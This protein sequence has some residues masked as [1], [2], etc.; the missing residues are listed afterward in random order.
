VEGLLT[1]VTCVLDMPSVFGIPGREF[2][3][4]QAACRAYKDVGIRAYVCPLI[5]DQPIDSTVAL[6]CGLRGNRPPADPQKTDQLI[7]FMERAIEELHRPE[8]GIE[9]G[10]GPSGMQ[11][12]SDELFVRCRELSEKHGLVQHT[13]LL[14]T[15]N[16]KKLAYEKYGCSAVEHLK[17]LGFFNEKTTCAHSVWLDAKDIELLKDTGATPVHNPLSNLRLGSGIAPVLKYL[18]ANINVCFGCDGAASNDSQDML[19]AIK[20]GSILHNITDFDYLRWITP[21]QAFRMAALGGA[22]AVG[23][24]GK[25]GLVEAGRSADLVLYDLSRSLSILPRTDILGLLLLGRPNNLVADVWVRGRRV[26][27][28]GKVATIDEEKLKRD[29]FATSDWTTMASRPSV[30]REAIEPRYR[31]VMVE[32]EKHTS[33]HLQQTP[34]QS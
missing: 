8:E 17:G 3:C 16:Q 6:G 11:M 21:D 29:L 2:E 9:I 26:V 20:M 14:E 5:G 4:L 34:P 31:Q 30:T 25:T 33:P 24:Q 1:G 12:C 22:R 13:H 10:L 28:D 23:L 15:L 32:A 27:Q 7:A 18:D 19:E